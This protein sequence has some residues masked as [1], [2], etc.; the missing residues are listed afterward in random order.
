MVTVGAR[1]I[2]GAFFCLGS[3]RIQVPPPSF[4]FNGAPN[5]IFFGDWCSA[6]YTMRDPSTHHTQGKATRLLLKGVWN[7]SGSL[8]YAS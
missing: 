1:F 6:V 3:F 5:E 2:N 8:S 4:C 7:G